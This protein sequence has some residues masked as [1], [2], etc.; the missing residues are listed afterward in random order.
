MHATRLLGFGERPER[1]ARIGCLALLGLCLVWF[2]V[3]S[4]ERTPQIDDA[5]ISFRYAQ[6]LVEGAGLVFNTGERV[7]GFTNLLWTLLIAVGMALGGE[8]PGVAH[9]LGWVSGLACLV[10]V[11]GFAASE[12]P[13]SR[14][15][16]AGMAPLVLLTSVAFP[17]WALSGLESP[18]FCAAVVSALW[19]QSAGRMGWATAAV[20]IATLTR[21][22]GVLLAVALFGGD[23]LSA[24]D[25]RLR[26]LG[27]PALFASGLV[28]LTLWRIAYYGHP[29][30]NT[31]YAKVGGVPWELGAD[32]FLRFL[33]DGGAFLLV[34]AAWG[35]W[36]L[37]RLRPAA[38]FAL[39]FSLYVVA[40]GGDAFGHG[41]FLLPVLA[42]LAVLAVAGTAAAFESQPRLGFVAAACLVL[43]LWIQLYGFELP[44][45]ETKR[46]RE[47]ATARAFDAWHEQTVRRLAQRIESLGTPNLV[48]TPGIGAFGY[49]SG[50]P[51][52][53]LLGLTDA[54]IARG[55]AVGA[56]RGLPAPGHQ[57]SDP[58]Y[59]LARRPDYLIIPRKGTHEMLNATADLWNHPDF[60]SLYEWNMRLKCYRLRDRSE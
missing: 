18:L 31:F 52:L 48:A 21:P 24:K 37:E 2:G 41:R 53:D 29:L 11:C 6:N 46:A 8:A 34:A 57:R 60:D 4:W 23:F 15:A 27:W 35:A 17:R 43:T 5:F 16:L 22:D 7:E 14:M 54:I 33:K 45:L 20:C 51:I 42:V 13:R 38:L 30:P 3:E 26:A 12:L 49:H 9:A 39:I 32:Y 58:D 56:E 25:A 50:F 55:D 1:E 36:S 40:V 59:V 10:A 28:A 47:I 19:A 44:Q